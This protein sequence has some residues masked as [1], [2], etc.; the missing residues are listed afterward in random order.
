MSKGLFINLPSHGHI[1]PTLGVVKE[2]I[3]RGEEVTYL[4]PEQFKEKVENVGARV[5]SYNCSLGIYKFADPGKIK[6]NILN[7]LKTFEA[8]AEIVLNSEEKYDYIVY[9]QVLAMAELFGRKLH[10]PTVCSITTFVFDENFI[11]NIKEAA[12]MYSDFDNRISC[13]LSEDNEIITIANRLR[14]QYN[15][16]LPPIKELIGTKGTI[17]VVYT[18]KYFQ[19]FSDRLDDTYKFV[20]PSIAYRKE[21]SNLSDI[22]NKA[23]G[24]RKVYISLG[25]VYNDS[26]EFYKKC[27]KAFESLDYEF[28]MSVGKDTSIK[29]LGSI[30]KNFCVY[31]YVPQLEVLSK[32]DA[33]ISH[34][35]MNSTNEALFFGVP[36]ILVPQSVDQPF[37][38]GRVAELG[39]GIALDNE[40]ITPELLRESLEKILKDDCYKNNI[41]KIKQSL[42]EAG[43]YKTAANYI[44]GITKTA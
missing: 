32:A 34:A 43:G 30:P 3:E 39:A 35:G 29:E 1:N 24:K 22:I 25:T 19:P 14:N 7:Y 31:N 12:M 28:I 23:N 26:A 16:E 6:D 11:N 42:R 2:L 5:K 17:S 38:A 33:F 13:L 18:S 8:L 20:G 44:Q 41:K 4:L 27:F 9:D 10:T 40:S 37:V 15:I 21:Q 36:T